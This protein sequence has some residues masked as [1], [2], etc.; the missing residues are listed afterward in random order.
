MDAWVAGQ[1]RLNQI[2]ERDAEAAAAG[3]GGAAAAGV[4]AERAHDEAASQAV[5][6]VASMEVYA[7]LTT[8]RG[9]SHPQWLERLTNAIPGI[10][11]T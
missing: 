1:R 10:L 5:W 6:A 2:V 4:E 11:A 9:W 3:R 7:K 8:E